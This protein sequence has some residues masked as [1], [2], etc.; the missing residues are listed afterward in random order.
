[1]GE[2]SENKVTRVG[3]Q[4][5]DQGF[6]PVPKLGFSGAAAIDAQGR[7]A[8]VVELKAPVIAGS[9]AGP[10]ATLVPATAVHAFLQAQGI[11]VVPGHPASEQ[12][13]V[14]VICVRR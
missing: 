1:L 8:G 4:L 7:L 2:G 5:T 13:V 10:Q 11:A 9:P 6:N 14:R 3:A 12:S